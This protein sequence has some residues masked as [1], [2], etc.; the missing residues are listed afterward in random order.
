MLARVVEFGLELNLVAEQEVD[1]RENLLHSV[2]H[3]FPL[4]EFYG[5]TEVV[6]D[7]GHALY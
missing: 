6:G 5:M 3:V 4:G 1:F 2:F 7:T